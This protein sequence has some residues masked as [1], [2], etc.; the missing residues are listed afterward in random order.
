MLPGR[1]PGPGLALKKD[2]TYLITV[3]SRG[4][5]TTTHV[6]DG[7]KK[8][9]ATFTGSTTFKAPHDAP[10]RLLVSSPGGSSGQYLIRVQPVNLTPTKPGTVFEVGKEGLAFESVLTRED[11]LDMVRKR[12]CKLYDVQFKAGKAYVI[13]LASKQFDAFLRLEDSAGAKLAQDDD[14][15]GGRNARI[16]YKAPRDDVY[17]IYATSLGMES[18]LF[19]LKVRE[20]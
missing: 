13:D 19:Q 20:E 4:F 15:G 9:L 1:F 5:F 17:R 10:L 11:P 16:K 7:Q 12:H 6:E 14:S 18:G 8:R 2:Q 3:E